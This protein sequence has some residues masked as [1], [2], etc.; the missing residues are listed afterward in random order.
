MGEDSFAIGE[1]FVR[2][3]KKVISSEWYQRNDREYIDGKAMVY[4]VSGHHSID[5]ELHYIKLENGERWVEVG[6]NF[7]GPKW[8]WKQTK[9]RLRMS[10]TKK[11][12]KFSFDLP[13]PT[14]SSRNQ[15]SYTMSCASEGDIESYTSGFREL[16]AEHGVEK[17]EQERTYLATKAREKVYF[18]NN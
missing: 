12:D 13:L 15:D 4:H 6:E 2:N 11:K 16:L 10:V 7:S 3:T 5:C 1:L 8:L 9:G 17:L 14:P 18:N